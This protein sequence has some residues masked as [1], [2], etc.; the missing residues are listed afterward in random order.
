M[1]PNERFSD[2]AQPTKIAYVNGE[3]R[4]LHLRKSHLVVN[5]GVEEAVEYTFDQDIITIGTR[6]DQDIPLDDDTVSRSHCRVVQD[7]EHTLVV[8]DGSTNGTYVNGVQVREAFLAPGSVLGVGNTQIRFNPVD[9]EIAITPSTAERLGDIVG[10][11]V[12]MREIFGI[13]EKI[14]PTG[15]TVI[16]E[17]ETGTGKEVV[18]RTIHQLSA[19]SDEPF[20]VFDCG[21]VPENL[22]ESELFGHEKG[23]FTG[24]VMTRKGLFEM[25]EGGTIFLDELGEL[26]LELQPKLLR[27][28]EQREVRRVGSNEPI[29]VNVRVIAATNRSLAEEVEEGRFRE[30]LFYRLSV[31][32]LLLPPLRDRI[33]DIP[34][35]SRHFLTSSGFN[36]DDQGEFK[37]TNFSREA[38][39][40]LCDYDWPG[41][42]RE[43]VNIIE[44][45]CSFSRGD[46]IGLDDLPGYLT[47]DGDGGLQLQP[48]RTNAREDYEDVPRRSE[49]NEM[50]FK[51]AK[52]EWIAS[53]ETDYISTLLA[54]HN[55]NISSA[56]READIDRKYFRKLMHKHDID[57]DEV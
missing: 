48:G 28:L 40:A 31:V 29:P 17:G 6:E 14:A 26:A 43:L 15:A 27:V 33:E 19:R 25:A 20:I 10:K 35:L 22:I 13:I 9:E 50:P 5:P 47:G 4:T 1:A 16:I 12:K 23:S 24:A 21:A 45:A 55:G 38:L 52:E 18:A 56:S 41:N 42:V 44:R 30:D 57:V 39:E 54:R 7:G 46:C 53:F 37:L 36:R 32:R 2:K 11:S 34:L 51:E 8:D 49:L 3:P